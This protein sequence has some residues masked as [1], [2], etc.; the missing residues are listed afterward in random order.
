[1]E[2]S[3]WR[4]RQKTAPAPRLVN[5]NGQ[6][7][8][9][10]NDPTHD[11][12]PGTYYL[13][14]IVTLTDGRNPNPDRTTLARFT[15]KRSAVSLKVSK[16]GVTLNQQIGDWATV[17]VTCLTKGY[18]FVNPIITKVVPRGFN[19]SDLD[20][21]N[22]EYVNGKLLISFTGE[23]EAYYGK[24][25]T[26][27][28]QA[29]DVREDRAVNVSVVIP[30][31]DNPANPR[32]R[33]QI[34]ARLAVKGFVD[35]VRGNTSAIITPTYLNYSGEDSLTPVIHIVKYSVRDRSY[36]TPIGEADEDFNVVRNDNG[37]FT[38]T[39][40]PDAQIDLVNYKY[41]AEM[42]FIG[43]NV[44]DGLTTRPVVALPVR[45]NSVRVT[46][47]GTPVLY[48]SDKYSRAIFRL[49]I[50]DAAVNSITDVTSNNSQYLIEYLGNGEC[51]IYFNT[52]AWTPITRYAGS[53]QLNVIV[54]GNANAAVKP[55]VRLTIK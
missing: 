5:V 29:R 37:T 45:S 13:K 38:V 35:I 27:R 15:V 54:D 23:T 31:K 4:R 24:T 51:A 11:L 10:A 44:P 8:L 36:L 42:S 17:D 18:D 40:K 41:R 53:V 25:F 3:A 6:Y 33:V 49:N 28:L 46:I 50:P 34:G 20:N 52:K 21:L 55:S 16:T 2:L 48:K 26:I 30:K 22:A 19:A 12:I 9:M 43:E 14:P 7:R 39:R 47:T 1:M 32:A